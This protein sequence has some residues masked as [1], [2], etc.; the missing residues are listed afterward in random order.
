MS[1]GQ[2]PLPNEGHHVRVAHGVPHAVGAGHDKLP[3]VVQPKS[4]DLWHCTDH[5]LPGGLLMLGFQQKIPEASGRNQNP[6][7]PVK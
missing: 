7:D 5:L 3:L 6:A 2:Q 4:L 1:M